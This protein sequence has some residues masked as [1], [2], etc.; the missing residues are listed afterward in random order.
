M[1]V[2]VCS[3]LAPNQGKGKTRANIEL[4][5]TLETSLT[6]VLN[7]GYAD[8]LLAEYLEA[9]IKA[10]VYPKLEEENVPQIEVF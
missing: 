2:K 3:L 7:H 6:C 9:G 4:I 5:K 8:E 1:P 10:A